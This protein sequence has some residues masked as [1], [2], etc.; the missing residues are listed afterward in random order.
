MRFLTIA[1]KQQLQ[2]ARTRLNCASE[3]AQELITKGKHLSPALV[4][5]AITTLEGICN[6]PPI[7]IRPAI[8]QCG[9]AVS[10]GYLQT[11]LME[12]VQALHQQQL[13]IQTGLKV[14]AKY[15]ALFQCITTKVGDF[16]R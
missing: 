16:T 15:V 1:E 4:Q 13:Y 9:L 2:A 7:A 8:A 5:E 3:L 6:E 14:R 12:Q 11:K 10:V